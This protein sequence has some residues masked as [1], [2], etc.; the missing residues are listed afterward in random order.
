MSRAGSTLVA[1]G[2]GES[3]KAAFNDRRR[4]SQPSP[5]MLTVGNY[6]PAKPLVAMYETAVEPPLCADIREDAGW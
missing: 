4:M 5:V 3:S 6:L 2:S 1:T